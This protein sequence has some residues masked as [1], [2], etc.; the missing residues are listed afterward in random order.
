MA[1]RT[2]SQRAFKKKLPAVVPDG[3]NEQMKLKMGPR[4]KLA[5]KKKPKRDTQNMLNSPWEKR[6]RKMRVSVS[7]LEAL[8]PTSVVQMEQMKTNER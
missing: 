7:Y 6:Y 8:F 1:P 5:N 3:K 2:L 4:M